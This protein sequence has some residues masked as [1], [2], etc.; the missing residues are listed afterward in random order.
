MKLI[1]FY[2]TEWE[3]GRG[4]ELDQFSKF[5]REVA[6]ITVSK[7]NHPFNYFN[8]YNVSI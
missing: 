1:L 3:G 5:K 4:D 7:K 6:V 8:V 2:I